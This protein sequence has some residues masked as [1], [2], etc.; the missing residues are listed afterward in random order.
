[1]LNFIS[2]YSHLLKHFIIFAPFLLIEVYGKCTLWKE[3]VISPLMEQFKT[4]TL[5]KLLTNSIRSYQNLMK[6]FIFPHFL[7]LE[8]YERGALW[9]ELATAAFIKAFKKATLRMSYWQILLVIR[10][11]CL[12][13]LY[14]L[15]FCW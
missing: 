1:M 6:N 11:I 14:L 2:T 13:I 12:A 9:K 7:Q 4:S 3:P 10:P 15:A 5:R 8:D